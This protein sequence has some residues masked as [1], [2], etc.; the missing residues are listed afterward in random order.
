MQL[1]GFAVKQ[2]RKVEK[3]LVFYHYHM[4]V[5]KIGL[6]SFFLHRYCLAAQ[7]RAVQV[8][9]RKA[10][11]GRTSWFGENYTATMPTK[12]AGTGGGAQAADKHGKRALPDLDPTMPL[13]DV[14]N[15]FRRDMQALTV[16]SEVHRAF[17]AWERGKHTLLSTPHCA[18][19]G[20]VCSLIFV[21]ANP[22]NYHQQAY[23][24]SKGIDIGYKIRSLAGS[25]ETDAYGPVIQVRMPI[26]LPLHWCLG[27]QKQAWHFSRNQP[28]PDGVDA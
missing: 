16:R 22:S 13:V 28:L 1:G 26:C 17:L 23:L 11:L 6:C 15:Y 25:S 18:T 7:A 10:G 21:V 27:V 20:C 5:V 24:D 9:Q 3:A 19:E 8:K 2:E 12:G 14:C 4:T